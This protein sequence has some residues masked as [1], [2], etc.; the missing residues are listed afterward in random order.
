MKGSELEKL[1]KRADQTAQDYS[2]EQCA[3]LAL[4]VYSRLIEE[5]PVRS[6]DEDPWSQIMEQMAAEWDIISGG[7]RALGAAA[8]EELVEGEL[9]EV[10]LSMG[11]PKKQAESSERE[12]EDG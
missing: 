3:D 8:I 11:L 10:E 5:S 6:D 4:S 1:R 2:L 7:A 12:F 9:S